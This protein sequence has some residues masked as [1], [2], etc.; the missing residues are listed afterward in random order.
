MY[1]CQLHA[2]INSDITF[3]RVVC[4]DEDD[5]RP[6]R[7]LTSFS[8][9]TPQGT[10]KTSHLINSKSCDYDSDGMVLSTGLLSEIIQHPLAGQ[11]GSLKRSA[12]SGDRPGRQSAYA[13]LH[14]PQLP[15]SS[16]NNDPIIEAQLFFLQ[17]NIGGSTRELHVEERND[18]SED[19]QLS[20]LSSLAQTISERLSAHHGAGRP[21]NRTVKPSDVVKIDKQIFG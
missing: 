16:F 8:D 5:I 20:P 14:G 11:R 1:V 3:Q 19:E 12:S 2:N 7:S 9:Y 13:G 15:P 6:A 4:E 10:N 18:K 21:G 17:N